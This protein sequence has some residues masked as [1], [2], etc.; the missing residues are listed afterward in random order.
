MHS[1]TPNPGLDT[2]QPPHHPRIARDSP[3]P[4]LSRMVVT[5]DA[6]D[7]I[8]L[9]QALGLEGS[10]ERVPNVAVVEQDD[11][12]VLVVLDQPALDALHDALAGIQRDYLVSDGLA[13]YADAV[14]RLRTRLP[15]AW[16]TGAFTV[17]A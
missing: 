14:A 1:G 16:R 12:V 8:V 2:D 13:H 4:N 6:D 3:A 15:R 10:R 11:A 17:A 9:R 5:V 7:E